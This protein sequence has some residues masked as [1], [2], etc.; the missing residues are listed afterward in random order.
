MGNATSTPPWEF[1]DGPSAANYD[2]HG[3]VPPGLTYPTQNSWNTARQYPGTMEPADGKPPSYMPNGAVM[4]N[5][6]LRQFGQRVPYPPSAASALDFPAAW[7]SQPVWGE[8]NLPFNQ[9]QTLCTPETFPNCDVNAMRQ[10]APTMQ[11]FDG[12]TYNAM[13]M[14]SLA[15]DDAYTK[16]YVGGGFDALQGTNVADTSTYD[17][18]DNPSVIETVV[19]LT[20]GIAAGTFASRIILPAFASGKTVAGFV[21]PV[22]MTGSF[23]AGWSLGLAQLRGWGDNSAEY[24]QAAY[25]IVISGGAVAGAFVADAVSA[26]PLVQAGVAGGVVYLSTTTIPAVELVLER[27]GFLTGFLFGLVDVISN[28]MQRFFCGL[29]TDTFEACADKGEHPTGRRWDVAS[30]AGELT[31]EVCGREGWQRD[32]PRAEFVFRGLVTGPAMMSAASPGTYT[33]FDSQLV[34]PL[35]SI[36]ENPWQTAFGNANNATNEWQLYGTVAGWDGNTSNW[37][38]AAGSNLYACQNWDVLRNGA[39]SNGTPQSAALKDTFDHWI[40]NDDLETKVGVLVQA[41][42]DPANISKMRHISGMNAP[43]IPYKSSCND[44]LQIVL[45]SRTYADRYSAAQNLLAFLQANPTATCGATNENAQIWATW[46]ADFYSNYV[47]WPATMNCTEFWEVAYG[48]N[49]TGAN[50]GALLYA[51]AA[52]PNGN[53]AFTSWD[54]EMPAAMVNALNANGPLPGLPSAPFDVKLGFVGSVLQLT[55]WNAP[56]GPLQLGP[57]FGPVGMGPVD[58]GP[59]DLGPVTLGPPHDSH[60]SPLGAPIDLGPRSILP[61]HLQG[62]PIGAPIEI[63]PTRVNQ[64]PI[65]APIDIDPT[66]INQIPIGAPVNLLPTH[67]NEMPI[68]YGPIHLGNP[69]D[70]MPHLDNWWM[71][72][73]INVSEQPSAQARYYMAMNLWQAG[74]NSNGQTGA[75]GNAQPTSDQLVWL[76]ANAIVYYQVAQGVDPVTLGRALPT[77]QFQGA[78]W[79]GLPWLSIENQVLW[80]VRSN[81]Q[82]GWA[83]NYFHGEQDSPAWQPPGQKPAGY[84][85]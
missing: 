46:N 74:T 58:L 11:L 84:P 57:R 66:R 16:G 39:Q 79:G 34:N 7:I 51:V 27:S 20:A 2:A 60:L 64:I 62:I 81:T 9:S 67:L 55:P 22:V 33:L 80:A 82:T 44:L 73:M 24:K 75:P 45:E 83:A 78:A 50:M 29:T 1:V 59:V 49:T 48:I 37:A 38:D 40:G 52:G 65:G 36:Y 8:G 10:Y 42:Y 18:C 6:A 70:P 77:L 72:Q 68:G 4:S 76:M 71:A 21:A 63:G 53:F 5:S 61:T 85:A 23:V 13:D 41:A 30:V 43:A 54:T 14:Y 15:I 47:N 26:G 28:G 35:G 69:F 12:K 3:Y 25:A 31:D 56:G 32:D 17:P 19:P